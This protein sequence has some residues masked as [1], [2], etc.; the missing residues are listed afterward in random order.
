VFFCFL[1]GILERN[2]R[3]RERERSEGRQGGLWGD[4][5]DLIQEDWRADGWVKLAGIERQKNG[6]DLGV[7]AGVAAVF[8]FVI[9]A[10]QSQN[11]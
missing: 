8:A 11:L 2:E 5:G 4:G 7:R 3:E 10:L 6:G 1:T 9:R